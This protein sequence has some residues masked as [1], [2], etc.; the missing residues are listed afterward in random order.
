M[1]PEQFE[2]EA[3]YR[4]A[5]LVASGML[6]AGLITPREFRQIDTMCAAKYLPVIGSLL[7]VNP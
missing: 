7:P 5:M 2:R 6:R 4:A 1:S 3:R